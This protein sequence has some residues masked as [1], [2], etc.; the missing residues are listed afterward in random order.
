M[1]QKFLTTKQLP[2]TERPYEKCEQLGVQSLTNAELL[3]AILQSGTQKIRSLEVAYHLLKGGDDDRPLHSLQNLSLAELRKFKGIGRV[4][5]IQ[6]QCVC[7]LSRRMSRTEA[8]ERMSMNA[9]D[10]IAAYYMETMRYY[11]Q[12]H[13][14]LLML[15]TK[16]KLIRDKVVFKGTVNAALIEPREIF[17][18]AMRHNAV[19][20]IIV[21]NHPS[22]DPTPSKE[23]ILITKRIYD[24]GKLVGIPL[25]DHII[26]GGRHFESLHMNGI[27]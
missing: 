11:Q 10:T 16:N 3:A 13:L 25:L 1:S 18:E 21:H 23:D 8:K 26:I 19:N 14:M 17:I 4:K 5:A 22:G 27:I 9:P 2:E 7:E 24:A 6:I 15:N 12:E 20:I